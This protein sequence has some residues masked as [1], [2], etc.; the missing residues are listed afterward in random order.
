MKEELEKLLKE[1]KISFSRSRND[2]ADNIYSK[3]INDLQALLD[4]LNKH[5]VINRRELLIDFYTKMFGW[6]HAES[7]VD[8]YLKSIN[9]L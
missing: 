3:I 5:D 9:S 1:Y 2:I 8:E 4:K 7:R 6:L